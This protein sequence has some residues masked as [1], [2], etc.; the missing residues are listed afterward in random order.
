MLI[1][2]RVALQAS[3]G[4]ALRASRGAERDRRKRVRGR[5]RR[6]EKTGRLGEQRYA[7]VHSRRSDYRTNFLFTAVKNVST[8]PSDAFLT[9]CY[10]CR[11]WVSSAFCV[12]R[13]APAAAPRGRKIAQDG[14]R[15]RHLA[16]HSARHA[17]AGAQCPARGVEGGIV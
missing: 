8:L 13:F 7:G 2:E 5:T 10:V 6:R 15:R 9:S 4:L 11:V 1:S 16:E 12:K 14:P 17:T 3:K